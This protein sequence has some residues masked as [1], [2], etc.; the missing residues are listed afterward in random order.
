MVFAFHDRL[1]NNKKQYI[2][3][4]VSRDFELFGILIHITQPVAMLASHE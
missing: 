2:L 1:K 3:L 4:Q